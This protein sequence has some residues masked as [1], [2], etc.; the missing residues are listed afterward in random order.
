M[1]GKIHFSPMGKVIFN[2]TIESRSIN[3][4]IP[5]SPQNCTIRKSVSLLEHSVESIG[6]LDCMDLNCALE[7]CNCV[8]LAHRCSGCQFSQ[9]RKSRGATFPS[10]AASSPLPCTKR[11]KPR[12]QHAHPA[13]RSVAIMASSLLHA[14]LDSGRAVSEPSRLLTPPRL[15]HPMPLFSLIFVP[16]FILPSLLMTP[17][18]STLMT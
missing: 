2:Y 6:A 10:K 15:C 11:G 17:P 12:L 16:V 7:L 9:E 4:F 14:L 3:T 5:F 13:Q 8:Q 18:G 1:S